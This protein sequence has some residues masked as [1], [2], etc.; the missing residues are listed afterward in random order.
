MG[1]WLSKISKPPT[2]DLTQLTQAADLIESVQNHGASF[3]VNAR[4]EVSLREHQKVTNE[5]VIETVSSHVWSVQVDGRQ[6]R[7]VD[8]VRQVRAEFLD[9]MQKQFGKSRVGKCTRLWPPE[10]TA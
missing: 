6:I 2:S 7:V 5:H 4:R 8:P 9:S 1:R 3:R 10:N